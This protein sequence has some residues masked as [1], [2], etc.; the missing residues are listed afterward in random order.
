M[1]A[2]DLDARPTIISSVDHGASYR[3]RSRRNTGRHGIRACATSEGP[4]RRRDRASPAGAPRIGSPRRADEIDER[5][6]P[7]RRSRAEGSRELERKRVAV[8]EA[9]SDAARAAAAL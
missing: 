3:I 8:D 1:T 7:R 2:L 9:E 6:G 5:C 4:L